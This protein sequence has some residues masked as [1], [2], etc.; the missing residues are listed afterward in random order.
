MEHILL[1]HPTDHSKC[2]TLQR[3]ELSDIEPLLVEILR[4]GKLVYDLPSIEDMRERRRADVERLDP[5]VKRLLNP[6]I[7]HVSLTDELW[8]LKQS[9]AASAIAQ[10]H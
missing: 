6:H 2:R 7:Y 8:K 4:D 9:L 3:D 5:G 1:R 10:S